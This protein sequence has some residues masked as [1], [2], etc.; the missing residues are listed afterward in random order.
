MKIIRTQKFTARG[1]YRRQKPPQF[2]HKPA[3]FHLNIMGI[4]PRHAAKGTRACR[5][6]A[7][8]LYELEAFLADAAGQ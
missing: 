3:T 1:T 7:Q 8:S 4:S 6:K 5:N 2:S